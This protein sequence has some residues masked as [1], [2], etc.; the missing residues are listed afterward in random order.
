MG[1]GYGCSNFQCSTLHTQLLAGCRCTSDKEAFLYIRLRMT[2]QYSIDRS[3][4]RK[5]YMY[6]YCT[7]Q[8]GHHACFTCEVNGFVQIPYM[9]A[10]HMLHAHLPKAF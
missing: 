8:L 10:V 7:Q 2:P 6:L 4:R 9:R 1:E 3:Q 5:D